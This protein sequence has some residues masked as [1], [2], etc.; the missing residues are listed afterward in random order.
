[1]APIVYVQGFV[2]LGLLFALVF[3]TPG[4]APLRRAFLAPPPVPALA[5]GETL[6]A[7]LRPD[8]RVLMLL[9][10]LLIAATM[11]GALAEQM[12]LG[13]PRE[14]ALLTL[15]P[16]SGALAIR[17]AGLSRCRWRLTDRRVITALGASLPLSEIG[18]IAVG[19]MLIR[20]DGRGVQSLRLAGLADAHGAARLIR[21]SLSARALRQ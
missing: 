14:I 18:R 7:E 12:L 19:P 15:L 6:I 9:S 20:L 10:G 1:M 2:L 16:F 21:D 17:L 8:P 4:L 5:P 13:A 11:A 3:L